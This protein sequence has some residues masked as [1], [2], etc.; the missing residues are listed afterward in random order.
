MNLQNNFKSM[1]NLFLI[2]DLCKE[3][4]IPFGE[5]CRRIGRDESTIHRSIRAGSTTLKTLEDIAAVLEVP[6]GYFF[7]GYVRDRDIE[8]YAKEIT[9]LKEMLA[10]KERTIQIL[11][12]ERKKTPERK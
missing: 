5:V 12:E 9:H 8:R 10:E 1:A 2:R 4:N 3:K 6:A 11:L 7:D